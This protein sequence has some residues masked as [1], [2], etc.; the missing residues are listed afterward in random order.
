MLELYVVAG[1]VFAVTVLSYMIWSAFCGDPDE[2]DTAL[3]DN[4][5]V[6]SVTL[7]DVLREMQEIRSCVDEALRLAQEN[8]IRLNLISESLEERR[9]VHEITK[10]GLH[11]SSFSSAAR[12]T[13]IS[14]L[15]KTSTVFALTEIEIADPVKRVVRRFALDR[16]IRGTA[17]SLEEVRVIARVYKKL[18]ERSIGDSR[19]VGL[20]TGRELERSNRRDLELDGA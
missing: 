11:S 3:E 19:P 13:Q 16:A 15:A 4:G 12:I 6:S 9:Y 20:P 10:P 14:P 2:G 5:V 1:A 17:L 8:E 18:Q 7:Q